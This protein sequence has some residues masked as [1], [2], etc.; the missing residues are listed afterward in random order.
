MCAAPG[1]T[2][3]E[4]GLTIPITCMSSKA[5]CISFS[6]SASWVETGKRP[7]STL[8]TSISSST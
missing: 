4:N 2:E 3:L 5:V 6:L 1:P 8:D 7:S